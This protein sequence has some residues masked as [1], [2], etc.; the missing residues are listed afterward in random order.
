MDVHFSNEAY[1]QLQALAQITTSANSDGFL[2][3]HRRGQV[4]WIEKIFPTSRGFFPSEEK[5]RALQDLF[6]DRIIGFFTFIPNE[7]KTKKLLAPF[8]CGKVYLEIKK[9]RSQRLF[10]KPFLIEYEKKFFLSPIR[11]R[12]SQVKR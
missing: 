6:Q 4:H 8:A 12:K 11:R 9:N 7:K 1:T 2:L 10:L 3:G 5:F